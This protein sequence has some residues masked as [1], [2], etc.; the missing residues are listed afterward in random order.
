[1]GHRSAVIVG[2][3]RYASPQLTLQYA[4]R[5]A[6]NIH[7]FL[8]T[9]AGGAFAPERIRLLRDEEA[10][11]RAVTQAVRSFLAQTE[12]DDLVLI[13]FACHGAPDTT[14]PARPLSL[15]VPTTA[16]PT[17]SPGLRCRWSR[18]RGPWTTT[19]ERAQWS[20]WQLRVTAPASRVRGGRTT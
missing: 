19:S 1:M 15:A 12:D 10:T 11:T 7:Q 14:A 3:S 13:Y 2:I 16:T 17:T 20:Y 6:E 9:P 4:H 5:D 18:S 8:L